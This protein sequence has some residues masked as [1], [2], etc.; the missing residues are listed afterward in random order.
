M[1]SESFSFNMI[2]PSTNC[3]TSM[4]GDV[5]PEKAIAVVTAGCF[6]KTRW[7]QGSDKEQKGKSWGQEEDWASSELQERVRSTG[8]VSYLI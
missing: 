5:C 6:A 7:A 1:A 2:R 4:G 8:S 3:R